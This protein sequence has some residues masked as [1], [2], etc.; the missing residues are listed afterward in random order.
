MNGF[1]YWE[2]SILQSGGCKLCIAIFAFI[3]GYAF[4]KNYFLSNNTS[5][6]K[7]LI[8][9]LIIYWTMLVLIAAPYL[10]FQGN[11]SLKMILCSFLAFLHND[12]LLMLSFSWYVKVYVLVILFLPFIKMLSNR[13]HDWKIELP[14]LVIFPICITILL[15]DSEIQYTTLPIFLL[16]TLR[17][18]LTWYPILHIGTMFGKYKVFENIQN[19]M[20]RKN[21]YLVCC[22]ALLGCCAS[23]LIRKIQLFSLFTDAICVSIFCIS[24][25]VFIKTIN[26][27]LLN[28]LFVFLGEY[29]FQYWLLS[30][31]FFLNTV[32]LQWI[33][34]VP[35]LSI[36]ILIWSFI[37]ITPVAILTSTVS[38]KIIRKLLPN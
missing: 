36:L 3:S 18:V 37:L 28:K 21:I 31:M 12:D 9:F 30:G 11:L 1:L 38:K 7:R 34:F 4:Y 29:S 24:A 6:F 23:I 15:P 32:E 22:L 10:T 13:V 27:K 19:M 14:V 5:I 2:R 33:L 20:L 26:N 8:K 25:V 16:S 35:K 17:L